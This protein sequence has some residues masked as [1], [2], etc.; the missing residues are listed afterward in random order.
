MYLHLGVKVRVVA[1]GSRSVGIGVLARVVP[2]V[3]C[4]PLASLVVFS[5]IT[6]S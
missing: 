1:G 2:V 4:R 5:S 6:R 3:L